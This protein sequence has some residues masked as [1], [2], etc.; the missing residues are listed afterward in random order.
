[1]GHV[2]IL[3][4]L[5]FTASKMENGKPLEG[6]EQKNCMIWHTFKRS[7]LATMFRKTIEGQGWNQGNLLE[8]ILVI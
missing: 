6:F 7:T 4:T 3:T 5:H 8:T 2:D 1:M